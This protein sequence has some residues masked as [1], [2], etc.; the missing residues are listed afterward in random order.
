MI[1]CE[2]IKVDQIE[3]ED[4]LSRKNRQKQNDSVPLVLTYAS[5]LPDIHNIVKSNMHILHKSDG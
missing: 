3:R 4:A 5:H 1:N 2:F